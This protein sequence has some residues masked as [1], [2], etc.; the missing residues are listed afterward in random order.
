MKGWPVFPD[1]LHCYPVKTCQRKQSHGVDEDKNGWGDQRVSLRTLA[2]V[3]RLNVEESG[4]KKKKALARQS[5]GGFIKS[6]FRGRNFPHLKITAYILQI[7]L[8]L[9]QH[10]NYLAVFKFQSQTALTIAPSFL[11][12]L[13]TLMPN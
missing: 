13:S 1:G 11:W 9:T 8:E 4:K 12:S 5:R 6:Q 10:T 7:N 2:E 3:S